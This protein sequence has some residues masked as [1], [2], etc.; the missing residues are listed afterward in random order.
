MDSQGFVPLSIIAGFKRIKSITE[1]MDLLRLVCRQLKSVEF[2]AGEDGIDRLRKRDKWDQWILSMELR[3]PSAQNDGPAPIS[4]PAD[5]QKDAS[6]NATQPE[7]S[8]PHTNGV[9]HDAP[10]AHPPSEVTNVDNSGTA[11]LSS[12]APEFT[13]LAST[14]AQNEN[15][16]VRKTVDE[17]SFPDEQIEN[18]VIVVRK[19][20]VSSPTPQSPLLIPS[21]RSFSSGFVDGFQ[22][23]GGTV[24]PE[25]R[26][27]HASRE[28]H[29]ISEKCVFL[30]NLHLYILYPDTDKN[31][32]V[33]YKVKCQFYR[34]FV[35]YI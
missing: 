20:G 3:D 13:P 16:N 32:Q 25:R 26:S 1:D 19:P 23:A 11:K 34:S 24:T 18:L 7:G 9:S 6:L 27:I 5:G 35:I 14:A 29:V 17:S 28:F 10:A 21:L 2:R 12:T 4:S 8:V 15:V 33:Q 31:S 30:A 22:T